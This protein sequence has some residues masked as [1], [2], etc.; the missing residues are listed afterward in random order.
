[1][2]KPWATFEADVA[3]ALK[4]RRV[5]TPW[6]LFRPRADV[7]DVD[8]FDFVAD[9]KLRKRAAHIGLLRSV[10]EKYCVG[11]QVPLLVC[12]E[13]GKRGAVVS[14]PLQDFAR[15]LDEVRRLRAGGAA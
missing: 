12:R 14:L 6:Q 10:K 2:S 7:V 5:T 13:S 8:G 1:M 15:L 11:S 4:G 9:C 3:R